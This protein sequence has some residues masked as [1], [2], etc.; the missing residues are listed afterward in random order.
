[1]VS[2][3]LVDIPITEELRELLKHLKKKQTYQIFLIELLRK[4]YPENITYPLSTI[5]THAPILKKLTNMETRYLLKLELIK[6]CWL[7]CYNYKDSKKFFESRGYL[8][9]KTQYTTLRNQLKDSG[10]R[11]A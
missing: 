4:S 1:M 6:I 11:Y 8:L 9:G 2:A 5:H 10:K 7:R 3:R